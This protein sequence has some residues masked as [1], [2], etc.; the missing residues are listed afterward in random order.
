[1]NEAASTKSTSKEETFNQLCQA[2]TNMN[3][4]VVKL[5]NITQNP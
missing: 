5:T 3:E 2:I 1:M 4:E